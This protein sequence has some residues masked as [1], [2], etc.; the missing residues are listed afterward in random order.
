MKCWTA[1]LTAAILA[2]ALL[3]GGCTEAPAGS[4]GG[5]SE[6]T[7]STAKTTT[8]AT[9]SAIDVSGGFFSRLRETR[10]E[11]LARNSGN[12][13]T[14]TNQVVELSYDNGKSKRRLPDKWAKR[15]IDYR[16]IMDFGFFISSNKTAFICVDDSRLIVAYS[17]DQGLTWQDSV[18]NAAIDDADTAEYDLP[19][20][21]LDADQVSYGFLDFP[22]ANCGYLVLGY[23]TNMNRNLKFVIKTADGGKTWDYV[24]CVG[25]DSPQSGLMFIN[26]SVGFMTKTSLVASAGSVCKT[27]DGGATWSEFTLDFSGEFPYADWRSSILSPYFQGEK[28]Y[29]PIYVYNSSSDAGRIIYYVSDDE[30]KTWVYNLSEQDNKTQSTK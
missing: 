25:R 14:I 16:R 18:I 1:G 10:S 11:L 20:N 24:S 22:T 4:D 5:S 15:V 21:S 28:G 6:K 26:D 7:T 2:A 30:G 8:T 23:G 13:V 3:L 12:T 29:L 19:S 17:D 9:V 27:M